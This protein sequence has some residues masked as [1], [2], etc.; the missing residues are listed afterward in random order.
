METSTNTLI[1]NENMIVKKLDSWTV[2]TVIIEF[3][4]YKSIL[5]I[6]KRS[7]FVQYLQMFVFD[8]YEQT[9]PLPNLAQ[10]SH[11]FYHFASML[12][13]VHVG[14]LLLC[15]PTHLIIMSVYE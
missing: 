11:F 7:E 10:A 8:K 14:K 9:Y 12:R 5:I 6:A 3:E 2:V 13:N 4:I 1:Q 15:K